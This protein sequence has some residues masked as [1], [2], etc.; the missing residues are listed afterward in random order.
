MQHKTFHAWLE[1]Q[2]ESAEQAMVAASGTMQER[3]GHYR[4]LDALREFERAKAHHASVLCALA[5][6]RQHQAYLAG[7]LDA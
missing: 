2:A 3:A 7:E 1:A 6:Y 5:L 4:F